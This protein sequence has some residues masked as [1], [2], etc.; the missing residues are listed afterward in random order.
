MTDQ[1][2]HEERSRRIEE[3]MRENVGQLES[4]PPSA[5]EKR[6]RPS[7]PR[8]AALALVV[9]CLSASIWYVATRGDEPGPPAQAGP[10]LVVEAMHATCSGVDLGAGD[11]VDEGDELVVGEGGKLVVRFFSGHALVMGRPGRMVIERADEAMRS[12]R[13]HE[14]SVRVSVPGKRGSIEVVGLNARVTAVST[15]FVVRARDGML[16]ETRVERGSVSVAFA[17]SGEVRTLRAGERL[18]L[19][20]G[21]PEPVVAAADEPPVQVEEPVVEEPEEIEKQGPK[22]EAAAAAAI[23]EIRGELKAGNT[24]AAV[25][26]VG[27]H[28]ASLG[29]RTDF[30]LLSADVYRRAGMIDQA[31]ALYLGLAGK[32]KGKHAEV[33]LLRAAELQY[34]ELGDAATASKTLDRYFASYP[35][36][37][38]AD[39]ALVLAARVSISMKKHDEALGLLETYLERYPEGSA[40]AW[41]SLKAGW[42]LQVHLG[43]CDRARPHL[44]KAKQI[45]SGKIASSAGKLLEAC[46]DN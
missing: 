30:L 28:Q 9:V 40:A 8:I 12:V 6:V 39:E 19:V 3:F 21:K 23:A 2:R 15:R 35:S 41:A 10:A 29:G 17:G 24:Q 14:G 34:R 25:D 20:D 38:L 46:G 13:L 18:A 16:T 33:A 31:V 45:G 26:L 32:S 11:A 22:P 44:L 36:G 1:D 42:I 43:S 5:F 27:K 4:L 7:P 37:K